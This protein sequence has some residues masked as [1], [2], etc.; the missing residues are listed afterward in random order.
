MP[1]SITYQHSKLPSLSSIRLVTLLADPLNYSLQCEI[2]VVTIEDDPDYETISYFWGRR[3]VD[4][5]Y[6]FA[7]NM[8]TQSWRSR[9]TSGLLYATFDMLHRLRRYGLAA[10]ASIRMTTMSAVT[11]FS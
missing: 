6:R 11:R 10:S 9:Q 7:V 1:A 8:V 2:D 5:R 4:H 3:R